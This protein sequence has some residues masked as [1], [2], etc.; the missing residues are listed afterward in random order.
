MTNVFAEPMTAWLR[1][2][3]TPDFPRDR[4]MEPEDVAQAVV[5]VLKLKDNVLVDEIPVRCL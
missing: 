5:D 2:A 3:A 1:W 4:V